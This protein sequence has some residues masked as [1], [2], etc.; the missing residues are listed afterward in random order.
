MPK[1]VIVGARIAIIAICGA[2]RAEARRVGAIITGLPLV[3]VDDPITTDSRAVLRLV[4]ALDIAARRIAYEN[5]L[6]TR[7]VIIAMTDPILTPPIDEITN[8][9]ARFGCARDH[10]PDEAAIATVTFALTSA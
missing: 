2:L 3:L 4:R 1:E 9:V 7:I 5:I 8:D 6:R 10:L